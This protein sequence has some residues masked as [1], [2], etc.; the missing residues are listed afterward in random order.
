[1][2]FISA[3]EPLNGEN[4]GSWR[5]K[6]EMGLALYDLDLA[7]IEACPKEP[8]DPVRGDQESEDDFNKRVGDHAPIRMKYD[9]DRAKWDS[10]N[11]KCLTVIK[12]S[13]LEA[14][15]GEIPQCDTASEYLKKVESQFT[16]SS[17]AYA[18]T[19][20]KNLVTT[21]YTGGGVRDHI[22]RMSHMSSKL[23]SM[24]MELPEQFIIHLIFASLPKDFETFAV[25]YNA[26]PE[27]WAI[28][29]MIAMCV[30]EE[31]R[32]KGQFGDS[33]NYASPTKK[34]NFQSSKPQGRPQWN[35]SSSKPHG[36]APDHQQHQEVDKDTCK[37]CKEKGHYQKDCVAFLKH[38]CKKGIPYEQDP[39]KRR[40]NR[41]QTGRAISATTDFITD[42]DDHFP[43]EDFF[44]DISSL[45]L[46]DMAENDNVNANAGAQLQ[47]TPSG[48]VA[49]VKP[50]LFEGTHYKRWRARA[51]LWFENMN[52][53]DATLGKPEGELTPAQEQVFQKTDR[54]FRAARLSVLGENIIEPYMS[55]TNGKDMWAALET[56]FEVSDA[57]SELYIMEQFCDF[58]M[59]GDCSVVEQAHEIQ[60]LAKEL[61]KRTSQSH[62]FKNKGKFDGKSKFDWKNKP[63]QS[64]TFKKKTDKKKGSCHVCGD[65]G[66]WAPSCPNRYDRRQHGKGGKTANVVMGDVDMKDVGYGILPTIRGTQSVLMG[67]GSHA[68]VHGVEHLQDPE[69]DDNEIPKRSKRQR[70]AKSF[71]D[72]FVVYL[73]DDTPT[74]IS[75]AY[76]SP[77]AD[78]WKEAVR[79]EMDSILANGTWEITDRPYG[80]KPVGC[81]WVFKKKLRPDG[82]IEKY[83]ARL[84]AKGYTQ[85]DGEDFFDTYSPVARLTTIRVLLS[86]AASH[87]LLVHQMDVKTAF[88]NG[89]L[90]EEIYMDQPDGF[91]V[92]GQERKVCKLLKSLYG[93][94]QAPKQ[95]HE[96]FDKTLNSAGF[97]VNEAD[98]CVYYRHGGGEGVIM[99]LYVDDILIFGT[100]LNVIK[101]VKDF[102]SLSF[103]MKDLGV[104]DVILNIKLMR[105][106][107]GGITLL[108]SHYV[109]K[110]SETPLLRVLYGRRAIRFLGSA[111]SATTDF[112]TD[113][114]DQFPDEDFF[115]DISSLYLDDMAEND[116]INANAGAQLLWALL[117]PKDKR[118]DMITGCNRL[119]VVTLDFFFRA[120]GW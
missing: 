51:V 70:T 18:S 19:L 114:D 67:N 96:K 1:M 32:I 66:H 8:K 38:L 103:E 33:V 75:E 54:L 90:D 117:L 64:T 97:V 81:K 68:S 40:K 6:I 34:R 36:K 2:S 69:K 94:K 30:Q 91:V 82:T 83:K 48:F 101:E 11:R 71:G 39:A 26:Q 80:C 44:P 47:F 79:S 41:E 29:K 25:N 99:C 27:K 112:I 59:T 104:A 42:F 4:Y 49:S 43:D 21:K 62:K 9:L 72:D 98:K 85:K 111:I 56:K 57:G 3:I 113:F 73:V 53:Y 31:E 52:C 106:D 17:K 5:E 77:D 45:Y 65:P 100:N 35:P 15:R 108:Q 116:N 22:L 115:P 23:K 102:L 13:I 118:K 7:L 86:L 87:G 76:A 12:S 109:E 28:E 107:D 120:T 88:L 10:S 37:W 74:S 58:K 20:I 95:W 50:P 46:D 89:E 119:L 110:A 105:D 78:Y 14:I 61:E 16:G 24:D 92:N 55:F 93:L 63:S 84:V 60:A